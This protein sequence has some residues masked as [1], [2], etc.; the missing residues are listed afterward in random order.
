MTSLT[1]RY[2]WA[3]LRAVPADQRHDLEPEIRALVADTTESKAADGTL[4]GDDAERAALTE[5]GDPETL[6]GRYVD[7]TVALIGPTI[8]P[9][10]RKLLTTLLP[11]V[12]PI[13]TIVVRAANAIDG[14]PVGTI[15]T[16]GLGAGFNV[17]VQTAFWFTL[18]FALLARSTAR[19]TLPQHT[20]SPERLPQVPAPERMG[21]ADAVA[22]VIANVIVAIALLWVQ[23]APPIVIDGQAYP[24]FDPAV[25]SFWLPWFIGVAVAE[26]GFAVL[27]YLRGRWTYG[28][29]VINAI[30]GAAFAIPAL[31]L[32]ANDM[33]F[34][35]ALVEQLRTITGGTWLDVAATITMIVIAVI[36]A[37]DAFDGFR[38]AWLN[39][40]REAEV[41]AAA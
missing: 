39:Q 36:V 23:L 16:S 20:W 6:A 37:W 5:L 21:I 22:T 32:L 31:Y 29:A 8:Y 40:R 41:P 12:V 2:V 25:F 10:W 33:A 38:K 17:A 24:L 28:L 15:I 14:K 35:P 27:L 19:T 7:R 4:T 11:I 30:L 34:N 9:E 1:D 18:V 3:V 26:I 13:V